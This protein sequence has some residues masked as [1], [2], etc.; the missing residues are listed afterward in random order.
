MLHAVLVPPS[1]LSTPSPN[2][3]S[4]HV[5][6]HFRKDGT[7]VMPHLRSTP[8]GTNHDN[9]STYPHSNP[10]TGKKGYVTPDYSIDLYSP[11]NTQIIQTGPRGGQY[12]INSNGNKTYVPKR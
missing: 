9:W 8:N 5:R 6:G 4:T 11:S 3:N 7:Y 10:Y 12:Y 1:P 2:L